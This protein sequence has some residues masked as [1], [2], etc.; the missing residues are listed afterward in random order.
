MYK[1]VCHPKVCKKSKLLGILEFVVTI[2]YICWA[3]PDFRAS[4]FIMK[5]SET[6]N[7]ED[8]PF[9]TVVFSPAV[10]GPMTA[11]RYE[12]SAVRLLHMDIISQS[13]PLLSVNG[14]KHIKMCVVLS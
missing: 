11:W 6:Q 9:G 5:R 12:P 8:A 13:A 7:T 14:L 2:I 4:H 10:T 3:E 1:H